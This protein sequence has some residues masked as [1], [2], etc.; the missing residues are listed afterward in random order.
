V[1][2][3]LHKALVPPRGLFASAKCEQYQRDPPYGALVGAAGPM[4]Y[5][6]AQDEA[7]LD[8][9]RAATHQA[10]GPHG[11]LM[12][13]LIQQYRRPRMLNYAAWRM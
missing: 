3:E 2:N 1:V 4:E 9:W 5:I 7:D 8:R 6:L 11:Q 13:D 10:L 12:V